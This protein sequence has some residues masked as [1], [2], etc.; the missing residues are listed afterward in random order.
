MLVECIYYFIFPESL[1][2]IINFYSTINKEYHPVSFKKRDMSIFCIPVSGS[3]QP[4]M[5]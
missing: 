5:A 1:S 4:Q 3:F 2:F